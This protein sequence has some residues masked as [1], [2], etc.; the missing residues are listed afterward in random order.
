[1]A[2]NSAFIM[3]R[4]SCREQKEVGCETHFSS[5]DGRVYL[6]EGSPCNACA[7]RARE[8]SILSFRAD[9]SDVKIVATGLRNP[10]GLA[11]DPTG[12][13]WATDNGRDDL[14]D[15]VP[16]EL[17]RILPGKRYGYPTC[18][19]IR[20]G[21]GCAGTQPAIAELESHSSADGLAFGPDGAA[22]VALWGTYFGNKHGRYVVRVDLSN[23]TPK[24]TRFATGFD[25][26][27]A[28][29]FAKDGAMLV[30]DWG[31]GIVWRIAG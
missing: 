7:P 6:G 31:T 15:A 28:V 21:S 18:Y 11:F 26:P 1:M 23:R 9:G 29:L 24:V 2:I 17:N 3:F 19:G 8:A 13:L 30:A 14:G 16:D 27:L 12:A 5:P 10:F 22:Y 4:K 20:R 25:H